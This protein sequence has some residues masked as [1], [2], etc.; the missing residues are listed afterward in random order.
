MSS[1]GDR[2]SEA[3]CCARDFFGL[4]SRTAGSLAGEG[5]GRRAGEGAGV[6]VSLT[7]GVDSP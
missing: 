4:G 5:A 7:S 6:G 2:A 1:S 3:S